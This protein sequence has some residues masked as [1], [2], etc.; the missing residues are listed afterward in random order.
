MTTPARIPVVIVTVPA[1]LGSVELAVHQ[2]EWGEVEVDVR[3]AG[4][5]E[6]WTPLGMVGGRFTTRPI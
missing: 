2:R 6:T 4:T 5:N 1:K 3:S